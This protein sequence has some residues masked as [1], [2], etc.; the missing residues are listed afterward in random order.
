MESKKYKKSK[1]QEH[2][3]NLLFQKNKETRDKWKKEQ[4]ELKEKLIKIDDH[5]WELDYKEEKTQ[6]EKVNEK[7]E[8]N[9]NSINIIEEEKKEK[10]RY[11]AGVD[12]SF[13]KYDENVG[14]SGLVVCDVE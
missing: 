5:K 1:G 3:N 9:I 14:I 7:V 6:N 4:N 13:D 8:E 12:I 2:Y 11:I 10:L